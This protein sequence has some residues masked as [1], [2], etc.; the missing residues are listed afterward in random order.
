MD[1]A[2][3]VTR[4]IVEEASAGADTQD[5]ILIRLFDIEKAYR[6]VSR[7]ALWQLR[8]LPKFVELLTRTHTVRCPCT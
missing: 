7:D 4:R 1:D 3:Q 8:G 5:V 6:R 2:L